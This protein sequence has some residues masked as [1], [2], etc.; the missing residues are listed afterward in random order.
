MMMHAVRWRAFTWQL[1]VLIALC[2]SISGD[3]WAEARHAGAVRVSQATDTPASAK[4][5]ADRQS[6]SLSELNLQGLEELRKS[7]WGRDPFSLPKAGE[8][9]GDT[10]DLTAIFYGTDSTLAIINGEMVKPGDEI[11]GR[12]IL[13]IGEDYVVVREGKAVRRL[14]V[15]QFTVE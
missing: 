12:R 5:S 14:E 13:S 3:G 1:A 10:L 9:F 4:R 2:L 11:D 7:R 15:R 8:V 6:A